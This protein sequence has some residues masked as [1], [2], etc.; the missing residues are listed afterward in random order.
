LLAVIVLPAMLLTG[1]AG[2]SSSYQ[3]AQTAT[4]ISSPPPHAMGLTVYLNP[5]VSVTG[6]DAEDFK[7]R[8]GPGYLITGLQTALREA[9]YKVTSDTSSPHD[10]EAVAEAHVDGGC[11]RGD[12]YTGWAGVTIRDG[13]RVI[14]SVRFRSIDAWHTSIPLLPEANQQHGQLSLYAA[15]WAIGR[16]LV[17]AMSQSGTFESWAR[18]RRAA[19]AS[20]VLAATPTHEQPAPPPPAPTPAVQPVQDRVA[21]AVGAP[22]PVSYALIV[23]IDQYRDAPPALGAR[24]DAEQFAEMARTTLGIRP[25]NL[26][27]AL[28]DRASRSDLQKHLDWL[29]KNVPAGGRIVFFYSGHG[30][31]DAAQGTPYLLPYDGD[32]NAVTS[33]AIPLSDVLKSLAESRA[34]EVVAF[35]DSCFSGAGGRSVLP[36]GARPLVRVKE[37]RPSTRMAV[38]SASAAHEIA[39][40]GTERAGGVFTKYLL[41]AIGGG[42]ADMDG[43]AQVSLREVTDWVTPRVTR[44][45]KREGRDQTPTL[46]VGSGIS[47]ARHVVV[48]HGVAK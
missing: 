29:K 23:G 26:R 35:V 45:A 19:Q 17:N 37:T 12:T 22:Q 38:L 15:E 13:Y 36:A 41:Q 43:D 9:G 7:E 47:D 39:G 48:A 33:T 6:E 27:I 46:I 25:D 5:K 21:F 3:E 1:C 34:Q 30:A 4:P 24:R 14:S 40:P 20:P 11:C 44:E 18:D 16:V 28:D 2:A 8:Q 10:C 32:P 31:P 42:Q